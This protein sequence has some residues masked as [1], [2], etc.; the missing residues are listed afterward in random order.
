MTDKDIEN[1]IDL[2]INDVETG[3]HVGLSV[4]VDMF[5]VFKTV[6]DRIFSENYL[7]VM[8]ARRQGRSHYLTERYL[9]FYISDDKKIC[10]TFIEWYYPIFHKEI[11]EISFEIIKERHGNKGH[12]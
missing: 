12:K 6:I 8:K 4:N 3:Y 7:I 11:R 1:L 5:E 9:R 2:F 10:K